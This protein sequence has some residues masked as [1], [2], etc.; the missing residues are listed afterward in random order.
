M[1]VKEG[2]PQEFWRQRRIGRQGR[3]GGRW[4]A[5]LVGLAHYGVRI[6]SLDNLCLRTARELGGWVNGRHKKD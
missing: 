1:L 4:V 3:G 5:V 2:V 6:H